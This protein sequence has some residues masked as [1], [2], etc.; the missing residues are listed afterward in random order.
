MSQKKKSADVSD[1]EVVGQASSMLH[2]D[3]KKQRTQPVR[4]ASSAVEVMEVL[5]V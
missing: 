2:Q 5:P 3:A 4:G 1:P